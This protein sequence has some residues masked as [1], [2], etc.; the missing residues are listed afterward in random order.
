[1]A[2]NVRSPA[3]AIGSLALAIAGCSAYHTAADESDEVLVLREVLRSG[4]QTWDSTIL[5]TEPEDCSLQLQYFV[6]HKPEV[7]LLEECHRASASKAPL[8]S[9]GVEGVLELSR[10]E[11][12]AAVKVTPEYTFEFPG[13]GPV[14]V[15]SMSRPGFSDDGTE[16]LV[17][18]TVQRGFVAA[19]GGAVFL[20]KVVS[21]WRVVWR[22][23]IWM[24]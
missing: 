18:L 22:E 4:L 21:R 2:T 16:A 17:Q 1:M 19:W 14:S 23:M 12:G 9:L 20:R 24:S 13:R 7:K 6:E 3:M 15:V 5:V 8:P 11:E 10:D